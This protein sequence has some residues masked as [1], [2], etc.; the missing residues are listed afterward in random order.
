VI[1]AAMEWYE[2][3]LITTKE[4][5]GLELEWGNEEVVDKLIPMI[6]LRQGF[7]AILAEGA[8]RAS[9]KLGLGDEGHYYTITTRGMTLPGDDPRGLGFAYGVGFAIGT[10][11][12]CDHLRCLASL[13]LSG[14]LYPGLNTKILGDERP[15]KPTTTVGKG[16]CCFYEENQKATTDCLQVCCFT[17]HW[18]YAVLTADQV[19]YLN[20]VTGLEFTEEEFQEI[21]ERIVNLERAY[22]SR[23]MSGKREDTIPERF[24]KE[25]MRKIVPDQTNEGCTFPVE[26]ILPGYYL[27]RD[28]DTAT[29]FPSERRLKMLGLDYVA[30]DLAPLRSKYLSE[31]EKKKK[32][33]YY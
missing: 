9:D 17:T 23:M 16:Y 18:S 10:R 31:A 26:K 12:G 4:T 22:W 2:K 28:Y 7:G 6:A 8:D 24:R 1:S 32:K 15:V 21:G 25:P 11:G 13:E 20:A 30:K 3:G 29:G 33:Y 27:Y 19:D 14:F 5:G